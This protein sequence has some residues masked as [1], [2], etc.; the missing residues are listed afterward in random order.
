MAAQLCD[1]PSEELGWVPYQ[2]P[3]Q[4]SGGGVCH[5]TPTKVSMCCCNR[6]CVLY[7][8]FRVILIC[9]SFFERAMYWS[10]ISNFTQVVQKYIDSSL[11]ILHKRIQCAHVR[12]LGVRRLISEVL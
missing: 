12:F 2:A 5:R 1:F 3:Q 4:G 11:V 6:E 9:K 7:I 10:K 8:S